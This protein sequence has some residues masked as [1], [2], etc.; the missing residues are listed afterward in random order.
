MNVTSYTSYSISRSSAFIV[1]FVLKVLS[2]TPVVIFSVDSG[3]ELPDSEQRGIQ[4]KIK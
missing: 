1:L 3:F 2:V 4:Y